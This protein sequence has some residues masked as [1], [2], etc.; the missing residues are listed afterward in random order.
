[1]DVSEETKDDNTVQPVSRQDSQTLSEDVIKNIYNSLASAKS[2]KVTLNQICRCL[3][4]L[5]Q[6]PTQAVLNKIYSDYTPEDMEGITPENIPLH[7]DQFTEI[8]QT[9]SYT[10]EERWNQ[11]NNAFLFFDKNES[12]VVDTEPMKTMLLTV[13]DCFTDKECNEFFKE[14]APG[15]DGKWPYDDFVK[16][17]VD[18]YPRPQSK[19]LQSARLDKKK[20]AKKQ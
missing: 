12:G 7:L 9:Y 20:I 8:I 3:Q 5:N 16:K 1:M 15:S 18:A 14:A 10:R 2:R 4:M 11:L 13:G 19:K 6:C 17:L